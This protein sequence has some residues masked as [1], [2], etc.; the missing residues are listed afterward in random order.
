M[1]QNEVRL[2]WA[3]D[4]AA[5][6]QKA[7]TLGFTLKRYTLVRDGKTLTIPEEK[8]FGQFFSE[9]LQY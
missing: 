3:V 6:W 1:K 4:Q 9:D 2:S 7:N 8:Y 5:A